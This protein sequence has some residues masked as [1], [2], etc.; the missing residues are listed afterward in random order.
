[1]KVIV[2]TYHDTLA[3]VVLQV[4]VPEG[5]IFSYWPDPADATKTIVRHAYSGAQVYQ[6]QYDGTADE[7]TA[8][9]TS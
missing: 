2:V 7:L 5:Q 3:D 8:A 4:R 1:M 9:L 6:S